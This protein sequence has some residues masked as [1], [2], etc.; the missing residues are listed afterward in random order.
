MDF[1]RSS[2]SKRTVVKVYGAENML[3]GI[4]NP[5]FATIM[6][7][8]FRLRLATKTLAA[9][10]KDASAMA[11]RGYRIVSDQELEGRLG[12]MPYRRAPFLVRTSNPI[13]WR[14]GLA[15]E[16]TNPGQDHL[17]IADIDHESREGPTTEARRITI[18]PNLRCASGST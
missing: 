12:R 6:G 2:E 1:A 15:T 17:R 18:L 14:E 5:L 3:F 16:L 11:K 10:E 7:E 8:S 9:L 13:E 4:V